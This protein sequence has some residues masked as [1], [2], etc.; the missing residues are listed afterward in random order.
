VAENT[1]G[2]Y[3]RLWGGLAV[4]QSGS[5]VLDLEFSWAPCVCVCV[6][7]TRCRTGITRSV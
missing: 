5:I 7:S 1:A 3:Q 4:G 2:R 6:N